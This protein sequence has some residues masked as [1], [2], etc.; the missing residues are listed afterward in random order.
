MLVLVGGFPSEETLSGL[1]RL[2]CI[3]LIVLAGSYWLDHIGWIV[4]GSTGFYALNSYWMDGTYGTF[5][6]DRMLVGRGWYGPTLAG[7]GMG[8]PPLVP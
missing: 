2:D 6:L 3:G 7:A 5:G 8:E 4:S 1:Y